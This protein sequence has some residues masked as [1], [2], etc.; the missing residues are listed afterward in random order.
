MSA[1]R[2][3]GRHLGCTIAAPNQSIN[4]AS[5]L[6]PGCRD[7]RDCGLSHGLSPSTPDHRRAPT[8]DDRGFVCIQYIMN[9]QATESTFKAE[10]KTGT[11]VAGT[12]KA[13]V[14]P[15]RSMAHCA[16]ARA[17]IAAGNAGPGPPGGRRPRA[18][19]RHRAVQN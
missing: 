14:E 12:R 5:L 1:C 4:Q 11:R 8:T 18:G 19:T 6:S 16:R 17:S 3:R 15:M 13:D 10:G 9:N 2:G 7:C